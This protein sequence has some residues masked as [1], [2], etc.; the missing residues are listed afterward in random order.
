MWF[1]QP[2]Y[3]RLESLVLSLALWDLLIS[4]MIAHRSLRDRLEDHSGALPVEKI[5][6]L[7]GKKCITKAWI[8]TCT[9]CWIYIEI[10]LS[11]T[12]FS[13]WCLNAEIQ[14]TLGLLTYQKNGESWFSAIFMCSAYK[15][16]KKSNGLFVFCCFGLNLVFMPLINRKTLFSSANLFSSL[17]LHSFIIQC[18]KN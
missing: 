14:Q 13:L 9:I 10:S 2:L 7:L 18:S 17:R 8:H 6:C 4:H 16:I 15:K 11:V 12:H 5:K 3:V 1:W